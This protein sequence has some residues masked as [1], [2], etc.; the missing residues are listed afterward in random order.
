MADAPLAGI[1][2]ADQGAPGRFQEHRRLAGWLHYRR[3]V[4]RQLRRRGALGAPGHRGHGVD[5]GRVGRNAA[6]PAKGRGHRCWRS[7]P[8][9]FRK[10][11]GGVSTEGSTLRRVA[12]N[13]V[14]P[15]ATSFINKGLDL[16]F[17]VILARSLGPTEL[18]RYT[19]V[20]LVASYFDIL[21]NFGLAIMISRQVARDH[22][23]A[24]R[25]MGGA[26]IAR[27]VLWGL[28]LLVALT[29]AGPLGGPFVVTIIS[30]IVLIALLLRVL[31]AI[32]PLPDGRFALQLGRSSY[33][34][35]INDFLAMLFFRVDGLILRGIAGDQVLG[36][37]GMAYKF[38]DGFT[39]VSTNVTLALFPLMSRLAAG[40]AG[41]SRPE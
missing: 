12:K 29:V 35:M 8:D 33:P 27:L 31:G 6:L 1:S 25:Y 11:L 13:T 26:L 38:I 23:S 16:V 3:L 5:R 21:I 30:A 19:W 34:L 9:S 18:G 2:R 7:P 10:R 28:T 40:S 39:I 15:T 17:A 20:V 37:Y 41:R 22:A 36:W 14:I 4:P 24:S 32:R